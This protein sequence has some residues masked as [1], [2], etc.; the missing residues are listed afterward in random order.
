MT[1]TGCQIQQTE[2]ATVIEK[3]RQSPGSLLDVLYDAKRVM[4]IFLALS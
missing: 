3:Y 4:V 1:V 2:L